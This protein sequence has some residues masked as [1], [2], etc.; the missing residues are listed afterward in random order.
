MITQNLTHKLQ[1]YEGSHREITVHLAIGTEF[2]ED[3]TVIGRV[4]ES[5]EDFLVIYEPDNKK[6]HSLVIIPHRNIT[7]IVVHLEEGQ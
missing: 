3:R 4:V 5:Q 6:A 1:Q 7:K 2:S